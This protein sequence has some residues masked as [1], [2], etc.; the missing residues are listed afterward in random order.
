M[1][2]AQIIE[3]ALKTINCPDSLNFEFFDFDKWNLRHIFCKEV[4]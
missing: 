1:S 3:T 2:N 4:K